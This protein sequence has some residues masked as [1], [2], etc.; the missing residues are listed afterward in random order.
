MMVE[1]GGAHHKEYEGRCMKQWIRIPKAT[2][3][4]PIIGKRSTCQASSN[5]IS[6][7]NDD[8]NDEVPNGIPKT[9]IHLMGW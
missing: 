1:E 4:S 8:V 6:L 5:K 9:L 2:W 7:I 3:T